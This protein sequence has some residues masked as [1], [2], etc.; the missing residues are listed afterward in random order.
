MS[1]DRRNRLFIEIDDG[2]A[3]RAVEPE[4]GDLEGADGELVEDGVV[5]RAEDPRT[6]RAALNGWT[7]L[8][9]V[10]SDERLQP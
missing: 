9:S 4:V 6:L 1:S 5:V 10:A 3:R 7:R 8:V 2:V